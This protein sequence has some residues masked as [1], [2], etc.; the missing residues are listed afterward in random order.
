MLHLVWRDPGRPW[1]GAWQLGAPRSHGPAGPAASGRL[2]LAI[3][4]GGAILR[5]SLRCRLLAL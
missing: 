1:S 3:G 2:F 5:V 4:L